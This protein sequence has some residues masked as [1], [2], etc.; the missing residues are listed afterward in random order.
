[1]FVSEEEI[2][3]RNGLL[4]KWLEDKGNSKA[5][6]KRKARNDKT[7]K[8]YSHKPHLALLP[9]DLNTNDPKKLKERLRAIRG[10]LR[11]HKRQLKQEEENERLWKEDLDKWKKERAELQD[12]YD[13]GAEIRDEIKDHFKKTREQASEDNKKVQQ[14]YKDF[15]KYDRFI[16]QNGEVDIEELESFMGW[17]FNGHEISAYMPNK[18]VDN[19]NRMADNLEKILNSTPREDSDDYDNWQADGMDL[20]NSMRDYAKDYSLT[21]DGENTSKLTELVKRDGYLSSEDMADL[22]DEI[23]EQD[24]YINDAE[25]V[26]KEIPKDKKKIETKINDFKEQEQRTKDK[27]DKVTDKK[28]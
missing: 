15:M 4:E 17:K 13:K 21:G 11:D 28:E 23:N 5:I 6:E 22:K 18:T 12:K 26:L 14:L 10:E 19:V 8:S 27:L 9:Y 16:D 7:E 24:Y 3:R 25:Q 1:M 20:V 2:K